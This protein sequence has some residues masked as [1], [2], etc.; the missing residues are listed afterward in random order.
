MSFADY[1]QQDNRPLLSA[2]F[3]NSDEQ[4]GSPFVKMMTQSP[5]RGDR[6]GNPASAA[7]SAAGGSAGASSDDSGGTSLP[8]SG[9]V[10]LLSRYYG[11]IS[12]VETAVEAL[13]VACSD[14][15][16]KL[17]AKNARSRMQD[18]LEAANATT[19]ELYSRFKSDESASSRLQA[20]YDQ[21]MR[22]V[23]GTS[24]FSTSTTSTMS[25]TT[26]S[27][28]ISNTV[29]MGA[30]M[31]S[32]FL[33]GGSTLLSNQATK[34][35]RAEHNRLRREFQ[36][37]IMRLERAT[38]KAEEM[39][40]SHAMRMSHRGSFDVSFTGERSISGDSV[41]LGSDS[42][43]EEAERAALLQA[44]ASGGAGGGN[45]LPQSQIYDEPGFGDAL[46]QERKAEIENIQSSMVK[47][48]D[49]YNDLAN[50]VDEQQVEID[51]IEQNI[52]ASHER[53]QAGIMQLHAATATQK[54]TG[55]CFRWIMLFVFVGCATAIGILYGGEIK[56]AFS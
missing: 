10:S 13:M 49:I 11:Q 28:Q 42:K 25:T 3:N 30:Q 36:R 53:T 37:E 18:A 34:K 1:G 15:S 19:K 23:A 14:S 17:A 43:A 24:S 12:S 39:E 7:A 38:K 48:N 21:Q 44:A 35:A 26:A 56:D 52:V 47:I 6:S 31:G 8:S 9:I 16:T 20:D 50:L 32:D 33:S 41:T 29:K 22:D 2:D 5:Q 45:A 55:K 27:A 51:D 40:R 46:V 54:T 4:S